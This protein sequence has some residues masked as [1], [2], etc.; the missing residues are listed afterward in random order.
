MISAAPSRTQL[1]LPLLE[2]LVERGGSVRADVAIDA[3]S[4]R[5]KI[6]SDVRND[7]RTVE[8][9]NWGPRKRCAWRQSVHWVRQDA[10]TRGLIAKNERGV[11]TVTDRGEDALKNCRPG[12]ILVVYET[13]N[14]EAIWA[15]A[16]TA[17]GALEANSVNLLFSSPPY[18]I[19]S[20]RGYGKFSES[21]VIELIINCATDWHRALKDDG[22][23]VLNFKDVWLPKAQTGGVVRSLYQEKL[24]IALAEDA[25]FFFADRMFWQ[26]PSHSPESPFVTIQRVRCN[27]DVENLLWLSKT[28]NP[29]ANNRNVAAEAKQS[30][31]DT[32]RRRHN[33]GV[34]KTLTGPSGQNNCFE[35]QQIA[36][37]NGETLKV[38]PRNLIVASNADTHTAQKR[39]LAEAG[40]SRH[41]AAMPIALA[42][43]MIKFLTDKGDTVYDPFHGSGT[44]GLAAER[45]ERR[46]IGS[47]RSLSHL[48][49]SSFR[50]G[51]EPLF[52][53]A[54]V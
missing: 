43:H 25:K 3:L 44:T 32:Y 30:T 53:P 28:P 8:F 42:D 37:A 21:E 26:N 54:T 19:V 7:Y 29:K 50:F 16:V 33:R 1:L 40:L 38:I 47:D 34:G 48:V 15:D 5:L 18:P 27:Q 46:W 20:G 4:D 45:L 23:M 36:V 2:T 14:G 51:Q 17:A 13:P 39:R 31:I 9:A 41:D 24:L 11:W 6:P 12:V 49:G 10:V 35:E 22:S 52:D